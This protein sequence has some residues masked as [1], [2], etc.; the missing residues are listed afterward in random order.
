MLSLP[1]LAFG[2][3]PG[4]QLFRAN[5]TDETGQAYVCFRIPALARAPNGSLLA[6]AEGRNAD[7]AGRACAD[8]GDVRIVMRASH[9]DGLSW[10]PIRQARRTIGNPV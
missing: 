5:A 10:S 4:L 2:R 7:L 3:L 1:A 9:D 6:F 8:H